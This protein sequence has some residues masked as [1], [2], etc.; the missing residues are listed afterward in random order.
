MVEIE[1]ECLQDKRDEQVEQICVLQDK[2]KYLELEQY[3]GFV[4][5]RKVPAPEGSVCSF[6]VE[7]IN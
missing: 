6:G 2:L 5:D 4:A 3:P 7:Q 1:I